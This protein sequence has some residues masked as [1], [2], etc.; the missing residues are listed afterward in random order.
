MSSRL[1]ARV[2]EADE[3]HL[4]LEPELAGRLAEAM[5]AAVAPSVRPAEFP[6]VTRPPARNGVRSVA[7]AS[8]VVSGRRNSSRSATVQP[9]SVKTDIGTTISSMTP[10]V[11]GLPGAALRLDRVRVRR[12]L[13][14]L[15]E[16]VVEVLGRL[17][18]DR[19]R[20]VDDPLGDETRVEVD[21]GAHRVVAHV[22]DAA[23][24]DDVGRAHGD[25]AG[26][27]GR[28]GERARAHAVDRE[29]R[30]RRRQARE[31]RDVAAERQAL[32]A[33]LR[34]R[35]EDDV[36]DPLGRKLRV[37][38]EKLAHRLDRH[39]VRARLREEPSGVARPNAVRTPST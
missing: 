11:P 19:R 14:Q 36:V 30:D 24:E 29:A 18:H 17:S 39:V 6:A 7:S 23:D 20:L 5:S 13:R 9:S 26:A 32:V 25:L 34:G 31:E 38:S 8:I 37:A 16:R 27:G 22:L 2:R 15:R 35:G 12:L 21:V 3:A 10:V 33:D 4:R 28:R 1:D